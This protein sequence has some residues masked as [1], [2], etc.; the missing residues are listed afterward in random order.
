M[1][2][3]YITDFCEDLNYKRVTLFIEPEVDLDEL[4]KRLSKDRISHL[5]RF[6]TVRENRLFYVENCDLQ[7]VTITPSWNELLDL[8][9]EGHSILRLGKDGTGYYIVTP[10]NYEMKKAIEKGIL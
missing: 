4:R 10:D 1:K 7:D 9:E 8:L 3:V 2:R 6:E 5:Y